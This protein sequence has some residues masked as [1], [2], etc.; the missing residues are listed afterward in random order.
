MD[1]LVPETFVKSFNENG[2]ALIENVIPEEWIDELIVEIKRLVNEFDPI[3]KEQNDLIFS[4]GENQTTT[5][6]FLSSSDKIRYF[7]EKDAWNPLTKQLTVPKQFSL[8]KIGHALH[9][10]NPIFR[11]FTFNQRFQS[12]AKSIGLIHPVVV[13]SM[14]IF[15]NAQYGSEVPEHQDA[16]YLYT[17]PHPKVVGFWIPLEDATVLFCT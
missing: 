10:Y 8:N 16:T 9:W 5:E 3:N 6:Y 17:T 13:Q 11:R 2:Y 1:N 12:I 15:K 14:I 7:L 4:P